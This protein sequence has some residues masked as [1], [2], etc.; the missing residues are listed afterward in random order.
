M[1]SLLFFLELALALNGGVGYELRAL[2]ALIEAVDAQFITANSANGRRI[3]VALALLLTEIK[4]G[5][6]ADFQQ[7]R[8]LPSG[9]K[10]FDTLTESGIAELR[11]AAQLQTPSPTTAVS[12]TSTSNSATNSTSGNN[13]TTTPKN[14]NNNN[15]DDG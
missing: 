8:P 15:D 9:Y 10:L 6:P 5:A 13:H 2:H 3:E 14:N 4:A 1:N 11:A 12:S 7:R